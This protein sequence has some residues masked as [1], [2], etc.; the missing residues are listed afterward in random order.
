VQ[1]TDRSGRGR[2]VSVECSRDERKPRRVYQDLAQIADDAGATFAAAL[3][4]DS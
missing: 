2:V 4:Y 1:C 3:A